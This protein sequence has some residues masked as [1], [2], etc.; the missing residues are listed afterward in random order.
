MRVKDELLREAKCRA[1]GC[2]VE[3]VNPEVR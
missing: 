3:P 2:P 1:Y